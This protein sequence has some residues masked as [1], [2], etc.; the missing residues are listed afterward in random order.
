MSEVTEVKNDMTEFS[1]EELSFVPDPMQEPARAH[2][3][4]SADGTVGK[5]AE[6]QVAILRQQIEDQKSAFAV[7]IAELETKIESLMAG[8]SAADTSSDGTGPAK[9]GA[10]ATKA[11][12][13]GDPG[14]LAMAAAITSL[15]KA[16]GQNN[17]NG[18]LPQP[19]IHYIDRNEPNPVPMVKTT[20]AGKPGDTPSNQK[21]MKM[22]E[23]KAAAEGIQPS[24]AYAK[25]LQTEVGMDLLEKHRAEKAAGTQAVGEEMMVPAEGYEKAGETS[26][27][28]ALERLAMEYQQ[29]HPEI[30]Y[31]KCYQIM[32][33][34]AKGKAFL[35]DHYDQKRRMAG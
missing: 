9:G 23:E 19:E 12:A 7:R 32:S 33:R 13:A 16:M 8:R 14:Q 6:D 10:Q 1:M 24:Q 25:L 20:A 29:A 35:A 4:K 34:T 17:A 5:A 3:I 18:Q 31:A 2:V 26:A 22:A 27:H 15:A 21:L 28:L 11:A 30:S